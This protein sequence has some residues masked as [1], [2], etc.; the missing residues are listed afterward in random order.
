MPQ[1]LATTRMSSRGQVVIPEAVRN[2]M[3]LKAGSHF[4]VVAED[5]V[6]ML[7]VIEPPAMERYGELKRRLRAQARAAGLTAED[8]PAAVARVRGRQ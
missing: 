5:D 7:K 3:G 6:V 2:Q 8:V 1:S 4:V